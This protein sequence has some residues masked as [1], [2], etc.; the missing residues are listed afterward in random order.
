MARQF[1]NTRNAQ[2]CGKTLA[3]KWL[4]ATLPEASFAPIAPTIAWA[5]N[6]D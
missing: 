3:V 4:E 5:A 1:G 2:N 6:G